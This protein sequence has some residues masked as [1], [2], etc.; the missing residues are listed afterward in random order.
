MRL[1]NPQALYRKMLITPRLNLK[2]DNVKIKL[3]YISK[4]GNRGWLIENFNDDGETKWYKGKM[5]KEIV[6]MITNKYS[7]INITWSRSWG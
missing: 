7:E 2:C 6:E 5:T 1:I 4:D 3:A